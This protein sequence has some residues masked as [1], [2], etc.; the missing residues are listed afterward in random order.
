MSKKGKLI[1]LEALLAQY[2]KIPRERLHAFVL[3]GQAY[4]DEE[5]LRDPKAYIKDTS[6]VSLRGEGLDGLSP[7]A[8]E[9]PP[10]PYVSRGAYKLEAALDAWKIPVQDTVWIDAGA[11]TGGFTHVLLLRKAR[12]VHAVDVGYNQLDWRLRSC[13]KVQVHERTKIQELE[14]FDEPA[15]GAVADLSF[16]S[17]SGIAGPLVDRLSGNI[18]IALI[19]PQFERKYLEARGADFSGIVKKAEEHKL[20]LQ[21]VFSRLASEGLAVKKILPSPLKGS[22]G[23]QEFLALIQRPG[24]QD[25][26]APAFELLDALFS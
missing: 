16:R 25:A 19:K 6:V 12:L 10:L 24:S 4:V 18:L 26:R 3:C 21:D 17:L 15:Y 13:A 22:K 7:P 23:N 8:G 11:S 1:F 2:P 5:K 14:P 20:I 9:V